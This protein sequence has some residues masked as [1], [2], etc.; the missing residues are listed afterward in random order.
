MKAYQVVLKSGLSQHIGAEGFCEGQ[1]GLVFQLKNGGVLRFPRNEVIRFEEEAV[2][3]NAPSTGMADCCDR[4]G[5]FHVEE[6]APQRSL[7]RP[8]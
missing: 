8:S 3:R 2:D 7:K 4:W 6:K 1:E 5:H